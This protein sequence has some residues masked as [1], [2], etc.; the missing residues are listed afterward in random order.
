MLIDTAN[1]AIRIAILFIVKAPILFGKRCYQLHPPSGESLIRKLPP[2]RKMHESRAFLKTKTEKP[3]AS[4]SCV[5]LLVA[6]QLAS[7]GL[8]Q[9]VICCQVLGS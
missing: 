2:R 7:I 6:A 3:V 8:C 1:A 4:P 9:L 5:L